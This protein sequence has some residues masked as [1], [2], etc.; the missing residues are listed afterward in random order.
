[1]PV[2]F[3]SPRVVWFMK[4][5]LRSERLCRARAT[6][7]DK[8]HRN[9][10]EQRRCSLS[11]YL[12]ADIVYASPSNLLPSPEGQPTLWHVEQLYGTVNLFQAQM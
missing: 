4:H 8:S 2:V 10:I 3:T 1:M 9:D 7:S 12:I 6:S 11:V 5:E